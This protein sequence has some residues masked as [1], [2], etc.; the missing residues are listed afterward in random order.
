MQVHSLW[1]SE[2]PDDKAFY[3]AGG[4]PAKFAEDVQ[5]SD[6]SLVTGGCRR[7]RDSQILSWLRD[8]QILAWLPNTQ[9]PEILDSDSRL[10]MGGYGRLR[11][12]TGGYGIVRFYLGYGI[13]RF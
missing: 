7:L 13:L 4:T 5:Q 10:V 3:V 2:E 6:S 12:V 1:G 8:T 9:I 11:E